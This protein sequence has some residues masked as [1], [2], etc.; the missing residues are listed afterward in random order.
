MLLLFL[1]RTPLLPVLGNGGCLR[2]KRLLLGND[3]GFG[4]LDD[5]QSLAEVVAVQPQSLRST[6][7]KD[8]VHELHHDPALPA[9]GVGIA[10]MLPL[11]TGGFGMGCCLKSGVRLLH[12]LNVVGVERG[13]LEL[14]SVKNHA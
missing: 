7:T 6:G 12:P 8:L 4:L 5:V 10:Q 2:L 3:G 1:L 9:Q 13:K 11:G 14:L